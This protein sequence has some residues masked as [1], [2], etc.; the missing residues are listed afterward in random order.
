MAGEASPK[1]FLV[2]DQRFRKIALPMLSDW[3]ILRMVGEVARTV[4]VSPMEMVLFAIRLLTSFS[5]RKLVPP[6][7]GA[8]IFWTT[9]AWNLRGMV[10]L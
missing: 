5:R 6:R 1:I 9:R 7:I 4:Q 10:S 3:S 8:G 2:L